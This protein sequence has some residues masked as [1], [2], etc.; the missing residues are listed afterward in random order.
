MFVLQSNTADEDLGNNHHN[1][2]ANLIFVIFMLVPLK[3]QCFVFI[4]TRGTLSFLFLYITKLYFASLC[5]VVE[6]SIKQFGFTKHIYE[7][8]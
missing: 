3:Q 8:F 4:A 1:F 7:R 5:F 2:I 6:R